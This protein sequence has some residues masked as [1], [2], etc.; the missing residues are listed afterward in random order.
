MLAQVTSDASRAPTVDL[1]RG[2]RC[3][4]T[5]LPP[6]ASSIQGAVGST[7]L[8]HQQLIILKLRHVLLTLESRAWL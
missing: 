8:K 1:W 6:S 7:R 3:Y 4:V 2:H 5:I